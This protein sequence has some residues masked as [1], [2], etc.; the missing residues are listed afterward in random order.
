MSTQWEVQTYSLAGWFNPV[1]D[2]DD[3]KPVTFNTR[4]EAEQDLKEFLEDSDEAVRQGMMEPYS[5]EEWRV[6][7][8]GETD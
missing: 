8:I 7:E 2:G 3:G 1:K 4:E 6:H 5:K